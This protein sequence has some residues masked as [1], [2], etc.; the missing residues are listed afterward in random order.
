MSTSMIMPPSIFFEAM[1]LRD[2]L[3]DVLRDALIVWPDP[4]LPIPAGSI[5]RP[6]QAEQDLG[7]SGYHGMDDL[8]E[9]GHCCI[10]L[11]T[12]DWDLARPVA[13]Y[14]N[15]RWI[16]DPARQLIVVA[17]AGEHGTGPHV[18]LQIHKNTVRRYADP[19]LEA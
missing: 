15:N 10:D 5:Y 2:P 4:T 6:F 14:I 12:Q 13:T 17:Y 7:R 8:D 3:Q 11:P 9:L 19:T 1:R 18:H 16:Y